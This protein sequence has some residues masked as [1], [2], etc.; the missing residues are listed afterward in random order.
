MYDHALEA[1]LLELGLDA[2]GVAATSGWE[3]DAGVLRAGI[4]R[5][6]GICTHPQVGQLQ[7]NDRFYK[8]GALKTMEE[9]LQVRCIM[10]TFST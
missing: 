10:F 7:R 3:V 2:R 9:V 4:R 6:R 8:P 5:L 1:V